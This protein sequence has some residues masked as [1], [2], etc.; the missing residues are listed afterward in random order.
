MQY[1]MGVREWMGE[2]ATMARVT[3]SNYLQIRPLTQGDTKEI[4]AIELLVLKRLSS[5]PAEK[6]PIFI[7]LPVLTSLS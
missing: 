5:N 6:S 2:K 3:A 1:Q 7:F 4:L